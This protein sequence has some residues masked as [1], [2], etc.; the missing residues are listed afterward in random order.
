MAQTWQ[1]PQQQPW[2]FGHFLSIETANFLG[3]FRS[4]KCAFKHSK[5]SKI[6]ALLRSSFQ[7]ALTL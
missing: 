5:L 4:K 3:G 2:W 7:P 1:I 6:G